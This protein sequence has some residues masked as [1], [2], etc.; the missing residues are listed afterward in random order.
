MRNLLKVIIRVLICYS[1][2]DRKFVQQLANDLGDQLDDVEVIYDEIAG[3]K[4]SAKELAHRFERSDVILAVVSPDYLT[5][6]LALQ[7]A[8][9]GVMRPVQ[10]KRR[11]IQLFIRPCDVRDYKEALNRLKWAITERQPL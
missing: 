5:S 11:L 10:N 3:R 1:H 7:Q 8:S 2:A 9:L 6:G 4:L